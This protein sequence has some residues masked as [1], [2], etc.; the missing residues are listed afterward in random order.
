MRLRELTDQCES[1]AQEQLRLKR[2]QQTLPLMGK[3]SELADDLRGM[4]DMVALP[5]DFDERRRQ[6]AQEAGNAE[7]RLAASRAKLDRVQVAV[8]DS[9]VLDEWLQ[10]A[11]QIE[12]LHECLGSYAKGQ[13]DSIGLRAEHQAH[14]E[15]MAELLTELPGQPEL[16]TTLQALPDAG[17]RAAVKALAP[18]QQAL[19]E[20]LRT[21]ERA[22][23]ECQAELG[24]AAVQHSQLPPEIDVSALR[25]TIT[26]IQKQGDLEGHLLKC[27]KAA[28]KQARVAQEQ[29]ELSGAVPLE[30]DLTAAR[31]HRD[32]GWQLIK[33]RYLLDEEI[34]LD[35]YAPDGDVAGQ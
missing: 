1:L 18:L 5:A 14:L 22:L 32:A 23:E 11:E 25:K 19:D 9:E 15:R 3:W 28:A 6:P 34:D 13:A 21:A 24:Q 35:A 30:G 27:G 17:V 16:A 7:R 10:R 20:A 12:Q 31:E 29:L 33:R 2:L 26:A 8:T 4:T